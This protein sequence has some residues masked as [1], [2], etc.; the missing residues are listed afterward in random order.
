M[1]RT[2]IISITVDEIVVCCG[3]KYIPAFT[4][5]VRLY[6][7]TVGYTYIYT[8]LILMAANCLVFYQACADNIETSLN[9][10]KTCGM[11]LQMTVL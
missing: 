5:V 2:N 8:D 6:Q 7:Q 10:Y 4:D 1:C 9:S 3:K 11:L